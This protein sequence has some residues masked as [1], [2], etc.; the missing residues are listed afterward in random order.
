MV[1]TV[2]GV[3]PPAFI[4]VNAIV[5]PDV[6]VPAAMAEQLLPTAMQRAF[7]DRGKAIFMEWGD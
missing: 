5:G 4:G 6:W 7:T 1:F 3:A 2:V